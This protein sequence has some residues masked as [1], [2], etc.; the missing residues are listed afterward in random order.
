MKAIEFVHLPLTIPG[1]PLF[2]SYTGSLLFP[3]PHE[4]SRTPRTREFGI[5]PQSPY[6][7]LNTFP[8]AVPKSRI[9]WLRFSTNGGASLPPLTFCCKIL[10]MI[11][12]TALASSSGTASP[13]PCE[14]FDQRLIAGVDLAR[15]MNFWVSAVSSPS[16][17][18]SSMFDRT[19]AGCDEERLREV[20]GS[21][22]TMPYAQKARPAWYS[23]MA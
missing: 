1:I 22:E 7:L 23:A 18:T 16:R 10:M 14:F 11:S 2:G 19:M 20:A 3:I 5:D 4:G 6:F 17:H 8:A 12:M 21:R 15:A 13:R 9:K